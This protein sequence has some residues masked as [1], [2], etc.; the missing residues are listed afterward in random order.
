MKNKHVMG[1]A[2]LRIVKNTHVRSFIILFYIWIIVMHFFCNLF[3]IKTEFMKNISLIK[4]LLIIQLP[5][6]LLFVFVNLF[7]L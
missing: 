7:N 1:M 2:I 3:F 4:L 6:C 5:P